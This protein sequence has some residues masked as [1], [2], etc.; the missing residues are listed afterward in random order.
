MSNSKG[1][2]KGLLDQLESL[3]RHARQGSKQTKRRYYAAGKRFCDYL[4]RRWRLQKLSNLA[5]KHIIDYALVMQDRGLSAS[6]I[7]TELAAIRY[8]HDQIPRPRYRLPANHELGV[9]LMRRVYGGV[10]R[11]WSDAE[12]EA[13]CHIAVVE[14]HHDYVV[15]IALGRYMGLRIHE[16][17]RIDTAIARAAL[18]NGDLTIKGKGGLVRNIPLTAEAATVLKGQLAKTKPGGKLLVRDGVPTHLAMEQL[19]AFI[20]RHRGEVS[21]PG[22][23]VPLTFHGLRHTYA[24]EMYRQLCAQSVE[25]LDA[26]CRV[27][28]RL[29]HRRP[30]VTNIYLASIRKDAGDEDGEDDG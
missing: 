14:G 17:Y 11:T 15:A 16:A 24:A 19:E 12:V 25:P 10:D 6:T 21:E 20:A 8:W 1:I 29:G 4:A 22:R 28:R 30:D 9:E 23:E 5:P 7:K 13:M 3:Y 26:Q 18:R 2:L 27:S